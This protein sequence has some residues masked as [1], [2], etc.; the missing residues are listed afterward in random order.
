VRNLRSTIPCPEHIIVLN[1][2]GRGG[3]GIVWRMIGSSPDVIMTTHEWHVG[4]FGE[5]RMARKG[6][7]LA[8]RSLGINSYEPLRR[9]VFK[10]TIEMQ[11]PEDLAKKIGARFCLIKLMDYHIVFADMIRHSFRSATFIN[12][13]R[14]PYGQCESLMRSGLSLEDASHW[15]AD[16]ARMMARRAESGAI[17][18]RFEDIVTQPMQA[19]DKLYRALGVRWAEDGRFDFKIKPYG[20]RRTEDVDV[21][22]GE[23]VR[24]GAEDVGCRID[25][26][27]LRGER[28]R[29]SDRQ[30]KVIWNLTGEMATR[31]GYDEFGSC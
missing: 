31:F 8:F 23:F 26:S 2:Y 10:K 15:Y 19:C 30:R 22:H 7:V 13:T 28:D 3:S 1:C 14:H 24:V 21:R 20:E 6:A 29:L 9:Y 25:P 17:A 27:V 16:V 12:L 18:V 11:R 5:A 4:V